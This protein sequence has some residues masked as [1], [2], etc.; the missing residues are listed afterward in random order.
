MGAKAVCLV[1]SSSQYA[2]NDNNAYNL[3]FNNGDWNN[4]NKN[5]TN[6]YVCAVRDFTQSD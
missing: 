4:N 3:N 2:S 5:N 1:W 6:N